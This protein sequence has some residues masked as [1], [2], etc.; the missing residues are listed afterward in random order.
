MVRAYVLITAT[1][2]KALE[3][4]DRLRSAPGVLHADAITGEYDVIAQVEA[5]DV[6]G[7]GSVIVENIQK[8]DGVFKTVTCLAVR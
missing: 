6:A 8:I 1:A 3:V 2:G 5:P 7:I 4:V